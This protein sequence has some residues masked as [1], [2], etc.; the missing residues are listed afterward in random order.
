MVATTMHVE[1]GRGTINDARREI[2]SLLPPPPT[3]TPSHD[4]PAV[5][6]ALSVRCAAQKERK[7]E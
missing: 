2:P 5:A 4:T 6:S 3:P 7:A 1:G